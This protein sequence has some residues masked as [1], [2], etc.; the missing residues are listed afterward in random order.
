MH[1]FI[2]LIKL[3]HVRPD[4]G[5]YFHNSFSCKMFP[6]SRVQITK[7]P[8]IKSSLCKHERGSWLAGKQNVESWNSNQLRY[9]SHF[10]AVSKF[11][12][13]RL[14]NRSSALKYTL[15]AACEIVWAISLAASIFLRVIN[16]GLLAIAWPIS[17]ALLASPC[18]TTNRKST[19]L[20]RNVPLSL[21]T[22][23]QKYD[24]T[25]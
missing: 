25:K 13:W 15:F 24:S 23:P 19:L 6:C 5:L 22:L 17:W 1:T 3:G 8:S 7:K 14:S 16:A 10:L 12:S 20:L 11:K 21:T 18:R 4:T 9:P 2:K